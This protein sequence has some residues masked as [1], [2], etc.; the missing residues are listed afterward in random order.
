MYENV[1]LWSP[2]RARSGAS[3]IS[4]SGQYYSIS[5]AQAWHNWYRATLCTMIFL[6]LLVC[7]EPS[8]WNCSPNSSQWL[9]QAFTPLW[10]PHQDALRPKTKPESHKYQVQ[11]LFAQNEVPMPRYSSITLFSWSNCSLQYLSAI[12]AFQRSRRSICR[13]Y[14]DRRCAEAVEEAQPGKK[15]DHREMI[16]IRCDKPN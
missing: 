8:D 11:E 5:P 4:T 12:P 6:F 14:W 1:S 13:W 3:D 7:V 2:L 9:H 16:E 10:M 15:R